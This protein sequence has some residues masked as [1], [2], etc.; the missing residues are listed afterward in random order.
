MRKLVSA[1]KY[2]YYTTVVPTIY[3]IYYTTIALITYVNI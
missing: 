2:N 3:Y 1:L